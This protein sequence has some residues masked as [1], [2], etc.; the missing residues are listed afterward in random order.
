M[1]EVRRLVDDKRGYAPAL[2][3]EI[4]E[5]GWT[6]LVIPESYGGAEL[7]FLSMA[8]LMEETGRC[9][10]PGPF[11]SSVL[12]AIAIGELGDDAQRKRLLPGIACGG[13][14]ASVATRG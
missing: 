7:D 13:T 1:S 14:R 3:E 11:S 4:A 6:G 2:M 10:L 8:L 9:L 5:L 12:A